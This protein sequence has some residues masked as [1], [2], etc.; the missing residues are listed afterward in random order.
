MRMGTVSTPYIFKQCVCQADLLFSSRVH[1]SDA[2]NCD[3]RMYK[4]QERFGENI[5]TARIN[6]L[7]NL[8]F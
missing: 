4:R 7:L 5:I 2:F 3:F 8:G 6:F 1:Y